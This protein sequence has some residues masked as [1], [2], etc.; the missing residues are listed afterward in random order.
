MGPIEALGT[1]SGTSLDGVDAAVLVTDGERVEAFGPTAYRPYRDAERAALRA[2]LGRWP[3]QQGVAGAAA[4]VEAAHAEIMGPLPG[5]VAAFHGQTLAHEPAR[6]RPHGRGTHQ[7]GDGARLAEALGRTVVWDLRSADVA[8]G[9]EG[10]P[11]APAYHHACA[12]WAG[13]REPVAFLNLGGVANLTWL[14]PRAEAPEAPGALLAFDAGP[15]N[16]PLDDLMARRRGAACDEGGALASRGTPHEGVIA[17]LLARDLLARP[18]PRSFDRGDFAGLVDAVEAL[19]D[20]V[21]AATL[22]H[23]AAACVAAGLAACPAPPA[24]LLVTGGGRRNAAAMA[25]LGERTGLAAEPVEAL[26]LDGDML[27]AQAFAFLAVRVLRGLPTSFPGTTGVRAPVSGGRVDR[28][29]ARAG[30]G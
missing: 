28:P 13:L 14:D 24:R 21:A 30:R 2:A 7:A 18:P 8:A 23:A 15:A 6:S 4:V 20:A 25:A 29:G 5:A 1:M 11:L 26:G 10:A 27:E 3:G 16:A 17:A 22:T 19:G 12:R 9:G